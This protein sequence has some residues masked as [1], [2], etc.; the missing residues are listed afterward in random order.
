MKQK[1]YFDTKAKEKGFHEQE[2]VWVRD[3]RGTTKWV[4]GIVLRRVLR[5]TGPVSY[6]VQVRGMIWRRHAEQLR[7]LYTENG[8][9]AVSNESAELIPA[10][11]EI[12]PNTESDTEPD[13]VRE[14]STTNYQRP[15]RVSRPPPRLTYYETL[16]QFKIKGGGNVMF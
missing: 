11:T 16:S 14:L 2:E 5:R 4:G 8:P 6:K 13:R 3:Y 12:E 9:V 15:T 1:V 7:V 10:E